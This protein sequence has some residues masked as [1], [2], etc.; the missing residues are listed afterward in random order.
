[1]GRQPQLDGQTV[2]VAGF[3]I[4]GPIDDTGVATAYL[5]PERGM[6]S[7]LPP[8]PPNQMIRVR[9]KDGWEP[10]YVHEPVQL[11]GRLNIE[12]SERQ[13][14]V[15]DGLMPLRATFDLEVEA[16]RTLGSENDRR[17]MEQS[18]TDRIR[19]AMDR[20]TGGKRASE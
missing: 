17:E 8:P 12:P 15:V 14:M 6:C 13:V 11:T 3:A 7:H 18:A 16:V 4:P 9:L 5:V 2:T 10:S 20:K 19:A 1:M